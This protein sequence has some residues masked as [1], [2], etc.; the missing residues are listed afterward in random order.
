MNFHVRASR[1]SVNHH[2]LSR[3]DWRRGKEPVYTTV[4]KSL[5]GG[6]SKEGK[7]TNGVKVTFLNEKKLS[8]HAGGHA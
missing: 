4:K 3:L 5:P 6:A 7:S 2:V 8:F 1:A